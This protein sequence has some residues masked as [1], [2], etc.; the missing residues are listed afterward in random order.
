MPPAITIYPLHKVHC[1]KSLPFTQVGRLF[2]VFQLSS[3]G[4]LSETGKLTRGLVVCFR[5]STKKR[6]KLVAR[7]F[8]GEV[9]HVFT[10]HL[11]T[12]G[13]VAL[14]WIHGCLLPAGFN[15][16]GLWAKQTNEPMTVGIYKIENLINHKVY[17]GQSTRI[18]RRFTEHRRGN[19]TIID[20]AIKKYGAENFDYCIIEECGVEELDEREQFYISAFNSLIPNGY[21]VSSGGN[22]RREQFSF[23]PADV[24]VRIKNDLLNSELSFEEIGKRY[25]IT[26]R[27]VRFINDGSSHFSQ[28]CSYPIRPLSI[29][30]K[31]ENSCR[32]C[33]KRISKNATFCRNCVVAHSG[34]PSKANIFNR[35]ELKDLVRSKSFEDIGRTYNVSGNAVKKWCDK[36]N[37][38]RTRTEIMGYTDDDWD[39]I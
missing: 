14:R 28:D 2:G 9:P 22:L 26:S 5:P 7:K 11:N 39:K 21:N 23:I 34:T 15:P 1:V 4:G 18:E 8:G 36:H 33:G 27:A 13:A 37:L 30:I 17:I 20:K 35:Q 32:D 25:G 38:P 29:S 24:I 16:A 31:E 19:S 12:N 6:K 3:S 10:G